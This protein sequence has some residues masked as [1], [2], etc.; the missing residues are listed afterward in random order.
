MAGRGPAKE[1]TP[2]AAPLW[3]E[4]DA[5]IAALEVAVVRTEQAISVVGALIALY[6]ALFAAPAMGRALGACA[7]AVLAWFSIARSLL[8]RP[9]AARVLRWA[10]PMVEILIPGV[11][12]VVMAHTQGAAYALGSWVPPMLFVFLILLSIV[13]LRPAMPLVIGLA[14]AVEYLLIYLLVLRRSPMLLS[15]IHI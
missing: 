14:G 15:L 12:L 11:G 3:A 2:G 8:A 9:G 13:R 5:K 4:F 7:L 1:Q 10:N 6:V